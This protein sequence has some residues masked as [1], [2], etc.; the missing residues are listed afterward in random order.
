MVRLSLV[1][2]ATGEYSVFYVVRFRVEPPV[3]FDKVKL[4]DRVWPNCYLMI[5]FDAAFPSDSL[6]IATRPNPFITVNLLLQISRVN[7]TP[8]RTLFVTILPTRRIRMTCLWV[9][10]T[11]SNQLLPNAMQYFKLFL[12]YITPSCLAT[13]Q[14]L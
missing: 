7:L 3:Y 12:S 4:G 6:F 11:Y 1:E 2:V 10:F 13:L 8:L 9:N 5:P 14:P